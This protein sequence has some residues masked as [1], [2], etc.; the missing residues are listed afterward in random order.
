MRRRLVHSGCPLPVV[1]G[2]VF[3][4]DVRLVSII[5]GERSGSRLPPL[6]MCVRGR[7]GR[8]AIPVLTRGE[9]MG[10]ATARIRWK[11]KSN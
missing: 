4:R 1:S 6:L 8:K 3:S 7:G 5:E 10:S 2:L 9:Q 11:K